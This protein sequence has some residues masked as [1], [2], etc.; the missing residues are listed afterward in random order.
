MSKKFTNPFSALETHMSMQYVYETTKAYA[1]PTN[2]YFNFHTQPTQR[3][4][5]NQYYQMAVATL[6]GKNLKLFTTRC[7][8]VRF[9]TY[10]YLTKYGTNSLPVIM[11]S[12]W[13]PLILKHVQGISLHPIIEELAQTFHKHQIFNLPMHDHVQY[14]NQINRCLSDFKVSIM[15]QAFQKQY[16]SWIT[17]F[18]STGLYYDKFLDL[19]ASKTDLFEVHSLLIQRRAM[20]GMMPQFG[21]ADFIDSTVEEILQEQAKPILDK[22]WRNREKNN[23]LGILSKRETDIN[24]T[25]TLRLVFFV[26]K[27]FSDWYKFDQSEFYSE[28]SP[29]LI[30]QGAN[31]IALGD[32]PS[33]NSGLQPLYQGQEHNYYDFN[34]QFTGERLKILRAQLVGSDF[35]LRINGHHPTIKVERKL[36]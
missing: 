35:W 19:V 7:T 26:G 8:D 13:N 12:A 20:N 22:I 1:S 33:M 25:Q 10:L 30:E 11:D 24:G 31:R 18:R 2:A 21:D 3:A 17:K 28:L 36:Y 27:E 34:Q 9:N 5:L 29:F 6:T 32:I 16:T 15:T 14:E 4:S 23:V